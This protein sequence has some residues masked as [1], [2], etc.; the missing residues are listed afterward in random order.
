MNTPYQ[1]MHLFV[2]GLQADAHD[3]SELLAKNERIRCWVGKAYKAEEQLVASN[4]FYN[5]AM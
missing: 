3:L 5:L 4:I 2:V 1:R